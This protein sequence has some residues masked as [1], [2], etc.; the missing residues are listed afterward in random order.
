VTVY[1]GAVDDKVLFYATFHN[2]DLMFVVKV[3]GRS[4]MMLL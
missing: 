3:V 1:T 2:A 4:V